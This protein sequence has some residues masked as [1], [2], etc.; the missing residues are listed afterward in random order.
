[1]P[2]YLLDVQDLTAQGQDGLRVAVAPLLGRSAGRVT[3]DEEYLTLLGILVGT[4]G[5]LAW[6]SASA[7]HILALHTLTRLAGCDAGRG[8]Q[9]DLLANLLGLIRMFLQ[10]I[11]QRLT[12]SLLHSAHNLVVAQLGLGLSL[13]LRFGHLDGD[14]SR[15]SLAEVLSRHLYLGLFDL[16]GNLR[17]VVGI[18]LQRAGQRHAEARDVR[19]ALDGVDIVDV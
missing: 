11:G 3:L 14:D 9:D 8:R 15:Q 7:H 10:V 17:V 5:K 2:L 4:V 12:D 16:L 13:K 6:Q 19:T 1:M 18:I